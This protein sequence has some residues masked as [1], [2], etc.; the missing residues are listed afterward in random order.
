MLAKNHLTIYDDVTCIDTICFLKHSLSWQNFEKIEVGCPEGVLVAKHAE[1]VYALRD[2]QFFISP[3][4]LG[5]GAQRLQAEKRMNV[6]ERR[7]LPPD[8]G[9]ER[10]ENLFVRQADTKGRSWDHRRGATF[11]YAACGR[12]TATVKATQDFVAEGISGAQPRKCRAD[13]V[14]TVRSRV[15]HVKRNFSLQDDVEPSA[16]LYCPGL[17]RAPPPPGQR[18]PG[19]PSSRN[20][21]SLP[22]P[23][24]LVAPGQEQALN[25]ESLPPH[26]PRLS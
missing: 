20:S 13:A 8:E 3:S 16:I 11:L 6:V 26:G 22:S 5:L 17:S 19:D 7:L 23:H 9:G 24:K 2:A 18:S 21:R 10:A 15:V 4:F 25:A 1:S 14:W 12:V